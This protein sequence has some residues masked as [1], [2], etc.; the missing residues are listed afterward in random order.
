MECS[1]TD[2]K[3]EASFSI[4]FYKPY[5]KGIIIEFYEHRCREHMIFKKGDKRKWSK[6]IQAEKKK[7]K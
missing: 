6:D 2:C 3:N 5:G 1:I 7:G 4:P